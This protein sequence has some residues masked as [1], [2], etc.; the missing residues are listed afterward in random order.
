MSEPDSYTL[1]RRMGLSHADFLRSLPS[2]VGGLPWRQEGGRILVEDPPGR[3]EI[4]LG[5]EGRHTLGAL[6]LPQTEV[7]MRFE[8]LTAE[9]RER[10]L[11]RFDLALQRGGG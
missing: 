6:A 2:A 1:V 4:R 11:R 5:P 9:A 7:A 3:I 8:G 10:F